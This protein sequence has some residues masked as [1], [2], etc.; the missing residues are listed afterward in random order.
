MSL[1]RNEEDKPSSQ[2]VNV[3]L[4]RW[5]KLRAEWRRPKAGSAPRVEVV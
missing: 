3:G 5:E 2:F 1:K 4:Q